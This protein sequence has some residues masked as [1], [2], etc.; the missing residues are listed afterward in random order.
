MKARK[1][2][3]ENYPFQ[4]FDEK[5]KEKEFP[6]DVKGSLVTILFNRD[7]NLDAVELLD[8]DDLAHKIRDCKEKE[9][10]LEEAEYQKV[11]QAVDV[12]KGFSRNDVEFVRRVLKAPQIEVEE[13]KKDE[14]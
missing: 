8:R 13:K 6:Y 10:L 12:F 2:N 7:L 9:V 1:I 4:G 5:G 14:E 3:L 11:K